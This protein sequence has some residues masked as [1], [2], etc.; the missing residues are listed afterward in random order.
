LAAQFNIRSIPNFKIWLDGKVV[1][2]QAGLMQS[3]QLVQ[4]VMQFM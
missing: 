4:Q 3:R 1:W 2:D